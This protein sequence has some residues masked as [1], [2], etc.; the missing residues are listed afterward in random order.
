MRGSKKAQEER[1]GD[2]EGQ[3]SEDRL[4]ELITREAKLL[5]LTFDEAVERAKK[6]TL[7]RSFIGDDLSLLIQLLPA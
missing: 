1:N 4:R 2:F 7:P 6:R 3:I 5:N